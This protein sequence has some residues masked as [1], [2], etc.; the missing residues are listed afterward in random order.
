LAE[1]AVKDAVVMLGVDNVLGEQI[2]KR[3]PVPRGAALIEDEASSVSA[4]LNLPM[5]S[6]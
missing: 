4:L 2:R 5:G 1:R 3:T 6:H